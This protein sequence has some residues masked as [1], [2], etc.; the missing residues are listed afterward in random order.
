M[1]TFYEGLIV[2][3]QD[4]TGFIDFIGEQYVTIC[5]KTFNDR[6]KNVCLLVYRNDWRSIREVSGPLS[7]T[8]KENV[9]QTDCDSI[10]D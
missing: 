9:F 1:I 4:H 10:N 2:S 6:S 7:Q 5:V 3:Y 8:K